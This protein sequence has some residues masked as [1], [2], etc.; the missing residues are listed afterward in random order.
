MYRIPDVDEMLADAEKLGIHV[1]V[2]EADVLFEVPS[3]AARRTDQFV[4]SASRRTS[5]RWPREPECQRGA[6]P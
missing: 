3:A 2:D 4:Q 5:P 1:A 6:A